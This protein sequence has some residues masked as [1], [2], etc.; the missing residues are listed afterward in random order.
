MHH[1]IRGLGLLALF[2]VALVCSVSACGSS[3]GAASGDATK[4]LQQTFSGSHVVNSGDLSLT[5]TVNPSGSS[6][7]T[8]PVVV[9]FA[10]PFQS[11]GKG[12]LPKSDFS[13][14]VSA[15]GQR[16]SLGILSTGTN[17]YVT[18]QG[19]SYQ[20][21]TASYQQL[22][23]SFSQLTSSSGSR[24]GSGTLANLGINPL[25]WL[26]NPSVVGSGNVGGVQTTHIH[27][28]VNVAVLLDD[29]STLLHK[30]SSLGVA[31]TAGIVPS[32]I[33]P[34][35][36]ARLASTV[37]NPSVDVWTGNSDKTVRRLA[38]N[39]TVPVTGQISALLG[40][41][42]SVGIAIN[43]QYADLNQPQSIAAPTSAQPYSAFQ[44]RIRPLLQA[45]ESALAGGLTGATTSGTTTGTATA[46]PIPGSTA[47]TGSG[48]AARVQSYS[49]CVTA[50][51]NDVAKMQKCASLL[52]AK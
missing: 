12:K 35:T 30:A 34:A 20:L 28:G 21:P 32:G 6:T 40:G 8:Q 15:Q 22:E 18:L 27:A 23:S 50:A 39:L 24:S 29:L 44:A 10:G 45:I 16:G 1:R 51:D 36:R 49:Q 52:N 42:R 2:T 7:V 41:L 4:L 25:H 11:L 19:A 14:S 46:I 9:T 47:A 37:H 31:G 48:S 17:G 43:L 3:S 13:I 38:I 26:V 5:V 33:A